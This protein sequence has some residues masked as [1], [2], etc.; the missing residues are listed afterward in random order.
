MWF[1]LIAFVW[2]AIFWVSP[3]PQH[4]IVLWYRKPEDPGP[5]LLIHCTEIVSYFFPIQTLN[6]FNLSAEPDQFTNTSD[7]WNSGVC[8]RPPLHAC[9]PKRLEISPFC[10]WLNIVSCTREVCIT[11]FW[12]QSDRYTAWICFLFIL[13]GRNKKGSFLLMT[14]VLSHSAHSHTGFVLCLSIHSTNMDTTVFSW[15]CVSCVCAEQR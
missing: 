1:T 3:F 5:R 7:R 4:L 8:S 10:K 15:S 12:P 14:T 2:N 9:K 13:W 11:L 6:R